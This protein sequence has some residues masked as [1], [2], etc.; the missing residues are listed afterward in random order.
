MS[1]TSP[2]I[3]CSSSP[4]YESDGTDEIHD[5]IATSSLG[6]LIKDESKRSA[7]PTIPPSSSPVIDSPP[8]GEASNSESLPGINSVDDTGP[9]SHQIPEE[10]NL[11]PNPDVT[12]NVNHAPP[13]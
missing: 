9:K 13:T 4:L 7:F 10:T 12:E 5:V 2:R 1:S 8:A 6:P 11:Q 3:P